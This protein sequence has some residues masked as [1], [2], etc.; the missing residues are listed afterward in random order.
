M[1]IGNV[2]LSFIV[3]GVFAWLAKVSKGKQ[4]MKGD[5]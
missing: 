2:N 3:V 5:K 1:R 4:K